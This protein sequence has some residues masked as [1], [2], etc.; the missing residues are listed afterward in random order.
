MRMSLRTGYSIPFASRV[1]STGAVS[2]LARTA[3][4]MPLK[5]ICYPDVRYADIIS[6]SFKKD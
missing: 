5:V 3:N 6:Y 4:E 1:L 2:N